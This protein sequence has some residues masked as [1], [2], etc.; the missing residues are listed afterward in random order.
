M[1]TFLSIFLSGY[2]VTR[3]AI[4]SRETSNVKREMP[5]DEATFLSIFI[6]HSIHPSPFINSFN[7]VNLLTGQL[8]NPTSPS[9]LST[10]H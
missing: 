9:Y 6:S 3:E 2:L 4:A 10:F 1:L 5:R 7:P 8:I